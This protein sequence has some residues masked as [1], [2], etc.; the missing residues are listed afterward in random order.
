VCFPLFVYR[1]Y[2]DTL[3]VDTAISSLIDKFADCLQVRVSIC[4]IWFNN[5]KHL[6]RRFCEA[7]EDP[8]IDLEE[9]EELE[10]F[11]R[12][13]GDFVDTRRLSVSYPFVAAKINLS[14]PLMR[15]T[16]ASFDSAGT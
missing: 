6:N 15:M 2:R 1:S 12:L 4:D 9:T 7:N 11:A 16:N 14:Y 13:G 10:R 3:L 5:P 8:I